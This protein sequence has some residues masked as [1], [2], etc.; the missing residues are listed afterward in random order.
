MSDEASNAQ[1]DKPAALG[2]GRP[3]TLT[4]KQKKKLAGEKL[5]EGNRKRKLEAGERERL[6]SSVV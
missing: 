2:A 4:K 1:G 5:N 3:R 6:V